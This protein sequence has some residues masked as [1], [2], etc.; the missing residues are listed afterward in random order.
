[1]QLCALGAI[2]LGISSSLALANDILKT[3]GFTSCIDDAD[4]KVQK[5]NISFDRST[6]QITFDAAGTSGKE[7]KVTASLS[8]SAYGKTVYQKDF[9]PC[10][11][12]TKVHQLCP[13]PAGNFAAEGKQDVPSEYVS[14]IPSIA[15]NIPDLE[16]QAKLELKAVDGGQP[17]ACI[18]S[19]VNNGKTMTVPA[20][21][22]VAVGIAGGALVLSGL[23][24]LGNAGT[25]GSHSPTP[26]FGTVVTWFQG[27]AMN[28]M[29][30]VQYPPVYQNYAKNFAF[31]SG[32]VQWNSMQTSIDSFRSK[33]GGNL[34]EDSVPYLRN[35]SLVYSSGSKSDSSITAKRGLDLAFSAFEPVLVTRDTD[36]SVNGTQAG[37]GTAA[38]GNGTASDSKVTHIV[39]GIQGYVEQLTIPQANTFMTVLLVFAIVLAAIA[40]V[41]ILLRRLLHFQRSLGSLMSCEAI[42]IHLTRRSS[43]LKS[44]LK[45]GLYSLLSPRS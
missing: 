9:N 15:F 26:G 24:A 41:S 4:I 7:Q 12:A 11:E 10:D 3:S 30:S 29:M 20:V 25:T 18:Q 21:S 40:V 36:V 44:F 34:T 8:V 22:Y 5:M 23:A 42:L 38:A 31:S 33:T 32:L 37:N 28:G 1:M 43:C 17:L 19:E 39:H 13:V 16:G 45:P 6:K 27:V 35:A 14:A 2:I